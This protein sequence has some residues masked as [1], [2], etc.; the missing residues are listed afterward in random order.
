[1]AES[2][3]NEDNLIETLVTVLNSP[4]PFI[5]VEG[6]KA[7]LDSGNWLYHQSQETLKM[8]YNL[9]REKYESVDAE[10][11]PHVIMT[12]DRLSKIGGPGLAA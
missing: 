3:T 8:L 9:L 4:Q 7:L 2:K 1:M 10:L 11:K 6:C 12:L 5:V